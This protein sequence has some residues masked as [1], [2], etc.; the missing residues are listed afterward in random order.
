MSSSSFSASVSDPSAFLIASFSWDFATASLVPLPS[1]SA[2]SL[3]ASTALLRLKPRSASARL[4][5]M[6]FNSPGCAITSPQ[7][8]A[9]SS[10]GSL[11]LG[12]TAARRPMMPG[13][14]PKMRQQGNPTE[15][16][17]D[18]LHRSTRASGWGTHR[19][20]N[21]AM[22]QLGVMELER[23]AGLSSLE[24]SSLWPSR[25]HKT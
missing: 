21:W 4:L 3:L 12:L 24:V 19:S 9:C 17:F 11:I 20:G 10:H 14:P 2:R 16:P 25:C 6:V 7:R 18:R 5:L 22:D 15:H 8:L 23:K 1:S 13:P